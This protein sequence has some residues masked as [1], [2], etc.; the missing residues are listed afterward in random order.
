MHIELNQ[1]YN[2]GVYYIQSQLQPLLRLTRSI[3]IV[4]R[5]RILCMHVYTASSS[6][7][8]DYLTVIV[9]STPSATNVFVLSALHTALHGSILI[10]GIYWMTW[11]DCTS[12]SRS[13]PF[14]YYC[15]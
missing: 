13:G 10:R 5:L 9:P 8:Q 4:I 15:S 1:P 12:A 2:S 6:P 3:H 14:R 11:V 7:S